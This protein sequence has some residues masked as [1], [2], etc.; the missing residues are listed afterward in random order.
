MY[1]ERIEIFND[2]A[3]DFLKDI[4]YPRS[5]RSP[6]FVYLDPPYYAKG[7]LLYLNAYDHADHVKLAQ[8]IRKHKRMKWVM[9][10]DNAPEIK[11]IYADFT[12]VPF[13]LS[14]SAYKHRMGEELLIHND[15]IRIPSDAAALVTR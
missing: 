3:L 10:Y 9:S 1:R 2:D 11:A 7:Q 5:T 4:V 12:R 14:H 8:F 6:V 13:D 15:K